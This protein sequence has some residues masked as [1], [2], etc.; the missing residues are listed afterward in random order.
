MT[1]QVK[2]FP[3]INHIVLYRLNNEPWTKAWSGLL[4]D[5]LVYLYSPFLLIKWCLNDW[6]FN[7]LCLKP[8]NSMATEFCDSKYFSLPHEVTDHR[9]PQYWLL[10][11]FYN[12]AG[13]GVHQEIVIDNNDIFLL[14]AKKLAKQNERWFAIKI[15]FKKCEFFHLW[16]E[17]KCTMGRLLIYTQNFSQNFPVLN[18]HS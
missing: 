6:L 9:S 4:L 3:R 10:I 13:S 14:G 17:D 15:C 12:S 2:I 11:T 16:V 7:N 8:Q 18:C 1:A 5:L